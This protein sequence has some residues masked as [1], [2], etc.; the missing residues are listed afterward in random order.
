MRNSFGC[1][2]VVA[3]AALPA[4]ASSQNVALRAPASDAPVTVRTYAYQERLAAKD[5]GIFAGA[6][7]ADGTRIVDPDELLSVVPASSATA[8]YAASAK[9][10]TRACGWF[11][12]RRCGVG[13]GRR[14]G[15]RE[16][17]GTLLLFPRVDRDQPG[18]LELQRIAA[19]SAAPV[20]R[21]PGDRRLRPTRRGADRAVGPRATAAGC[22]A[23]IDPEFPRQNR[24]PVHRSGAVF[25]SEYRQRFT[26]D[27]SGRVDALL[28]HD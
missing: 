8:Q 27:R 16:R 18:L 17:S 21:S 13:I 7:L 2:L 10:D 9:H 1:R 5:V 23:A 11:A 28:P 15:G 14:C 19:A 12:D 24:S 3:L 4:C 20:R 25:R 6:V 22:V 26:A